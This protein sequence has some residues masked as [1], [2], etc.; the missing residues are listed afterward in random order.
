MLAVQKHALGGQLGTPDKLYL[1]KGAEI[2][3]CGIDPA[4]QQPAFWFLADTETMPEEVEQH[5]FVVVTT[6]MEVP[7]GSTHRGMWWAAA[8]TFHMFALE[9]SHDPSLLINVLG[10]DDGK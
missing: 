1:P 5:L 4:T 10:G 2:L 8:E 9:E 6:G 3:R 7:Y